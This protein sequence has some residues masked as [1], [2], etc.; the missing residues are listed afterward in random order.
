MSRART[1]L[2]LRTASWRPAGAGRR[3][4]ASPAHSQAGGGPPGSD[5]ANSGSHL[6][7][8]GGVHWWVKNAWTP[9]SVAAHT[10][11][12]EGLQIVNG[13]QPRNFDTDGSGAHHRASEHSAGTPKSDVQ[14]SPFAAHSASSVIAKQP[15]GSGTGPSSCGPTSIAHSAGPVVIGS[16]APVMLP[17][18]GSPALV[19]LPVV[20][21]ETSASL[22]PD[23]DCV[24]VSSAR[25]GPHASAA[26]HRPHHHLAALRPLVNTDI[27]RG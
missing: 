1:K 17:V 4:P 2:S 23:V 10:T 15:S 16:P 8:P 19:V 20:A 5:E 9:V 26:Q 22:A 7:N 18:V 25:D 12:S 14:A 27:S 13:R 3:H 21:V 24:S 11:F 6:P